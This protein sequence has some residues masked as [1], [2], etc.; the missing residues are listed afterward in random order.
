[1]TAKGTEYQ[2]R[3]GETP[4]DPISRM[5]FCAEKKQESKDIPGVKDAHSGRHGML[6]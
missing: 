1:M 6:G 3:D 2:T 4:I 5:P